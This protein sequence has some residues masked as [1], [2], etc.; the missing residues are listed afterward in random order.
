MIASQDSPAQ[1]HRESQSK[2]SRP[3]QPRQHAGGAKHCSHSP[4]CH[5]QTQARAAGEEREKEEE[6]GEGTALK[7]TC[8]PPNNVD[9]AKFG[10]VVSPKAPDR[11]VD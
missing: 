2:Y 9:F 4:T 7:N 1:S 5:H 10:S 3:D 6:A 11:I 8:H